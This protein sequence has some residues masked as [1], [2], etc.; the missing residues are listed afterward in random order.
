MN[1]SILIASV[2]S[3]FSASAV[4]SQ[5]VSI[6]SPVSWVTQRNDSIFLR[7]QV[8]TSMLKKKAINVSLIQINNGKKK[9][10]IKKNLMLNDNTIE[11]NLGMAGKDLLGGQEF[12]RLEWAVPDSGEKGVIEPVGIINLQKMPKNDTLKALRVSDGIST[13]AVAALNGQF[14]KLGAAEFSTAWNMNKFFILMKKTSDEN[15]IRF[16][17]DGK[18]GKNAFISYPDRIISYKMAND[19]LSATH[20][21]REISKDSLVYSQKEWNCEVSKEVIGDKV[22]ISIPW[23]DLGVI[24]FEER[25]MGFG[26]FYQ[27]SSGEAIASIP[28]KA[29]QFIPGTWA[30]I[31]LQK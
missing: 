26:S 29:Q 22:V 3:I 28:K 9:V 25:V 21:N 2:V 19:S 1:R 27:K 31:F 20:F 14:T 24:P 13:G 6:S 17:F 10:L 11:L 7:A 23:A 16:T 18:N 15:F 12:L 4:F 30:D 8:D 5:A